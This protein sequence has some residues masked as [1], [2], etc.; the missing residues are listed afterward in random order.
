MDQGESTPRARKKAGEK[1]LPNLSRRSRRGGRNKRPIRLPSYRHLT[2]LI[3]VCACV[4]F[5][6]LIGGTVVVRTVILRNQQPLESAP[7]AP[8]SEPG[9][10]SQTAPV[11]DHTPV[12]AIPEEPKSDVVPPTVRPAHADN[13]P[14]AKL[15]KM[16]LVGP[17]KDMLP[18]VSDAIRAA[19]P[20]DIIEV[21][22][23]GPLLELGAELKRD[24]R[25][26]QAPV[27]I[28]NGNGFQPVVRLGKERELYDV[29]N[30]DLVVVGLHFVSNRIAHLLK[31]ERGHVTITGC[32]F[33]CPR[34]GANFR[35]IEFQNP[36]ASLESFR[37]T[38]ERCFLRDSL[39]GWMRGP[40]LTVAVTECGFLGLRQPNLVDCLLD[41]ENVVVVDHCTFIKSDLLLVHVPKVRQWAKAPITCQINH[42]V[43]GVHPTIWGDELKKRTG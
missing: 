27:T 38:F 20:G 36:P 15:A 22:T 33:N 32:T 35:A 29:K 40:H 2:I 5:A 30:V 34:Q 24:Q 43:L 14:G 21:R 13:R 23:N 8:I 42:S 6:I 31:V 3:S 28:R 19:G 39:F 25:V 41:V 4:A 9:E 10:P 37:A 18:T 7:I 16:L 1:D 11:A 26:E 17:G 12:A